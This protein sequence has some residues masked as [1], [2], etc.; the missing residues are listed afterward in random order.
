MG[1]KSKNRT[2]LAA[3]AKLELAKIA[4]TVN[5]E[6][7]NTKCDVNE[8]THLASSRSTLTLLPF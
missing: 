8:V 7:R 5:K 1:L 2:A 4:Q 3:R 6:T